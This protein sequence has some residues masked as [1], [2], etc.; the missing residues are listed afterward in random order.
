MKQILEMIE[1]VD[2]N[3]SAT[4]IWKTVPSK[5]GYE[6]SNFGRV[7]RNGI[8]KKPYKNLG[9]WRIA[10]HRDGKTS[11][12]GVASFIAE[13]FHGPRPDGHFIDHK[14]GDKTNDLPENL[15]YVTPRENTRRHFQKKRGVIGTYY[16]PKTKRY[17]S[18][19]SIKFEKITLGWFDTQKEAEA[20]YLG[21]RKAIEK[22]MK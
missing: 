17:S 10:W 5:Q 12:V 22:W 2:V 6:A 14:D 8:I 21:A 4:E 11:T 15:E 20:A 7:R 19:I 18:Q 3:D 9:Y 13:A 16:C 1:S